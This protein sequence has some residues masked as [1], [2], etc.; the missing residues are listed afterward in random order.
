MN[1][2]ILG[3]KRLLKA[4]ISSVLFYLIIQ[5]LANCSNLVRL[6]FLVS[7]LDCPFQRRCFKSSSL[8][9][10]V[11]IPF[12]IISWV[13]CS[14]EDNMYLLIAQSI[15]RY[16]IAKGGNQYPIWFF[17]LRQVL[18][19][20]FCS[21]WALRFCL[22]AEREYVVIPFWVGPPVLKRISSV[23]LLP[24]QSTS[25]PEGCI[26]REPHQPIHL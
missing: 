23:S 11:F 25:M 19:M 2:K 6:C 12:Q 18:K 16:A 7:L 1:G 10:Q 4:D 13:M 17:D 24:P 3:E 21:Q 5:V 9:V 8:R 14:E 15:A 26:P 20:A 22:F